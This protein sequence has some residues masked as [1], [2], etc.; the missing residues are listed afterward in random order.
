[1][2]GTN[3]HGA[4]V[5]AAA[6]LLLLAACGDRGVHI[7]CPE[8][9]IPQT[10]ERLIEYREGPGRD[11]TD[12]VMEVELKFLSGE[13]KV[14]DERILMDFPVAVG[15]RRGPANKSGRSEVTVILAVTDR[16]KNILQRREVPFVLVFPG[17]RVTIVN[18]ERMEFRIP[19]TEEQSAEDFLVFLALKVTKEQ[20]EL[21]KS[22]SR[23]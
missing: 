3:L 21:N 14:N 19:K 17:N 16:D 10:T 2:S 13:C 23:Q 9:R 20:R 4:G 15:A 12:V 22:R 11:I 18:A 8:V 6:C 7:R 5:L 1:M